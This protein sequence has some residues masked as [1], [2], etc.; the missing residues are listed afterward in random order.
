MH[1][2]RSVARYNS[3]SFEVLPNVAVQLQSIGW[4]WNHKHA[5]NMH[6]SFDQ[7]NMDPCA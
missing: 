6:A 5:L 7:L 1:P 3:N 4:G 2:S